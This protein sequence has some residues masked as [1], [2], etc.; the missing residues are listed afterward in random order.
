MLILALLSSSCAN[1]LENETEISNQSHSL[2]IRGPIIS[3][4]SEIII[5]PF[6]FSG[7]W[8]DLDDNI[9]SEMFSIAS[10]SGRIIPEGELSYNASIMQI[11]YASDFAS[12]QS[13]TNENTYPLIP[14]FGD[15]YVPT[16]DSDA[17]ELVKLL[18]DSDDKYTLK[19]GSSLELPNGY[20]LTAKQ[21]DVEGDK[22]W[23]ELSRNGQYIEDEVLD[24][25]CG[26]V[27]WDYDVD[28]GDQ[29]DVIVFRVLVTDIFQGVE[30][31]IVFVEGL[32]LID[33][34][35]VLKLE[36]GNQFDELEIDSISNTIQMRNERNINLDLGKTVDIAGNM[37]FKVADDDDLRFYLMKEFTS[38]GI[39]EVRG[40]IATGADA[41]NAYSF[42]GFW[43]DLD[44]N[45]GS[46]TLQISAN[47]QE[48]SRSIPEDELVYNA[49]LV[50][51]EYAADF[52]VESS[53]HSNTTYPL[54][55]LFGE[56][57]VSLSDTS[58]DKLAK[59]LFDS[60]ENY[61]LKEGSKLNLPNEFEL[62]IKQIDVGNTTVWI[63]LY[64]EGG[65]IDGGILDT[66]GGEVSW[67]CYKDIENKDDVIIF[68]AHVT[69]VSEDVEGSFVVVEGLYL[70]DY[71]NILSITV[72]DVFGKLEVQSITSTIQMSNIGPITLF[73][74]SEIEIAPNM[75]LNVADDTAL[76]YYPFTKKYVYEDPFS[77]KIES[78][79]P[80]DI[81]TSE[82]KLQLFNVYT[83]QPAD[84]IWTFD[85]INVQA[86][87]SS[88]TASYYAIAP[89]YGEH[90][91]QVL[92]SN[93]NNSIIK[94][95]KWIVQKG[96]VVV[97]S[98]ELRSSVIS[99]TSDI[100]ITAYNF[101][102]L[103]CDFDDNIA[104]EM[105][106][107][108]DIS[109]RTI[110]E[111]SLR[112]NA[113]IVQVGY[114]ADFASE[115]DMSALGYTYPVVAL[116][117]DEYIP[118]A[119]DDAGELVKLLVD[120]DDKLMLKIG[121]P[122]ELP[123]GYTLTAKQIDV[124][125][126][127]VWMELSK[128]GEFVEDE[129][130][131][132]TSGEATWDYD[133]DVGDQN[134]VIV[135]RLLVT[136][137]FQGTED[138][139]IC[140][141]G[142]YLLDYENVFKLEV[143]NQFG[144]LEVESISST[145]QMHNDYPINLSIGETVNITENM[146]F[147]VADD[148]SLRF[149]L[150]KE[151][152]NP[153]TYE[154][155]GNIATDVATWNA[156]NFPGFWYDL[157]NNFGSEELTISGMSGNDIWEDGL[158]YNTS[159]V[160]VEY[161]AN[162]SDEYSMY[163]NNTY[164]AIGLF[165]EK[166]VSLS[167]TSPDKLVKLLVDTDENY[168]LRADSNL[169]LPNGFELTAKQFDVEG[170]K[171]WIELSR[172][173]EFIE[174]QVISLTNSEVTWDYDTDVGGVDDVIVFRLLIT[175]ISED[176]EG[177]FVTITGL[178]LIE[179]QDIL[180]VEVGDEFVELEVQSISNVIQM[181][182]IGTI[183]LGMDKLIEIAPGIRIRVAD[184]PYLRYYPFVEYIIED[185]VL[186]EIPTATIISISP[187]P[188]TEHESVF[189]EG[190]GFDSDGD[191]VGYNWS[192]SIDGWLSNSSNFSTSDLSVGNHTIF[193]S[194]L[195]DDDAWSD[196]TST[197]LIINE[198]SNKETIS[199]G[200]LMLLQNTS[201]NISIELS[202]VT[203]ITGCSFDLHYNS[204]VAIIEEITSNSNFT[205]IGISSNIDNSNGV[206]TILFT[207][208]DSLTLPSS[209]PVIFICFNATGNHG[210]STNLELFNV[211]FSDTNFVPHTPE[212]I[213]NGSIVVGV[214]GDFNNNGRVDIGDVS[215][216]AFMVVGKVPED[217]AADFNNNVRVDIGDA[218]KIAFYL[219]GKI[220]EL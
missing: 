199:I 21:L 152:R 206:A 173:G 10:I 67:N 136:D 91:V 193:F 185:N 16:S 8:Y 153:G 25:T 22:V 161:A 212:L 159:I 17:G 143:G 189:F 137:V 209:A 197:N 203:D 15:E 126:D 171:V 71:Q 178:Y 187:N 46:E 12:E 121:S 207:C 108:S 27:T 42:A 5:T 110:P 31:S 172:N 179:Y 113:S 81:I 169:E 40:N 85:G 147:K 127:K 220:S 164:P 162:F 26:V 11:D 66:A 57:Y 186:N 1:A 144:E 24:L 165:G 106:S 92:A 97:D 211:E 138:G 163:L 181:S 195:D 60:D 191:L 9:G 183:N 157:D 174:D 33:Y 62:N 3:I 88:T 116:F 149:Y 7:F 192:S 148:S 123:N 133:V 39:Y 145:I 154:L 84:F 215:K 201:G 69:E 200:N 104:S 50:Q 64:K 218:S 204:S 177:S 13:Y 170:D 4:P 216:V 61:V 142:I 210:D 47:V 6:I 141:E 175:E 82:N 93:K 53:M 72:G 139:I 107:I 95:W 115:E 119:D 150:F 188:A 35:N 43:C 146:K 94:E 73:I 32:Y 128:N 202:G 70:I 18:V 208:T 213:I 38:P 194:V 76:R 130:V 90:I 45:L 99:D 184:D 156:L 74:D 86:N 151:Y 118:T 44:N 102:G 101:P 134:D 23:M 37:K 75:F 129:V 190:T 98:M 80:A 155:R 89:S 120:S 124:E 180:S 96:P 125:G 55:G 117:G 29:D 103:W 2:E 56:K 68:R 135:F 65:F 59:L 83:N 167:D 198:I 140:I 219:A 182:N 28:V 49:T 214:N 114:E 48:Y 79:S 41:W 105:L 34:Q 111:N 58:P 14:L 168:V 20:T 122:L 132:V 205:G 160:Q 77:L 166:Y 52:S 176:I 217:L 36:C 19:A 51:A 63:E 78:S 158:T 100:L 87:S 54:I 196:V 112:Y 109:G 131:D 30:D